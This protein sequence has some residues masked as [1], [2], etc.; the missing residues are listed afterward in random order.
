VVNVRFEVRLSSGWM[1]GEIERDER[2]ER[3]NQYMYSNTRANT[4]T[5]SE[6]PKQE[7]VGTNS[8]EKKKE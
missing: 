6:E 7:R 3:D 5:Q 8:F 4:R 2:A 1:S